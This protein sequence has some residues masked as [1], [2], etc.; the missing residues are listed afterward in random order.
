[1]GW[2]RITALMECISN[3][4]WSLCSRMNR[5]QK[6]N[7]FYFSSSSHIMTFIGVEYLKLVYLIISSLQFDFFSKKVN[8]RGIP[9]L[10]ND[11]NNIFSLKQMILQDRNKLNNDLYISINTYCLLIRSTFG[12]IFSMRCFMKSLKL[13]IYFR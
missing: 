12:Y 13:S 3:F 5:L 4:I 6:L 1:M 8:L 2:L 11:L 7:S 9:L 10:N